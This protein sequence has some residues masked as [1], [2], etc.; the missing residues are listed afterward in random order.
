MIATSDTRDIIELVTLIGGV[1][2]SVYGAITQIRARRA[3]DEKLISTVGGDAV[4]RG[5]VLRD[6]V[7]LDPTYLQQVQSTIAR[8]E[9]DRA[10]L[11][12]E[13]ARAQAAAPRPDPGNGDIPPPRE[14]PPPWRPQ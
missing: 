12:A 4:D 6:I 13:L 11:E 14:K 5:K 2:V 8:F 10:R 9:A 3:G 1:I 7:G